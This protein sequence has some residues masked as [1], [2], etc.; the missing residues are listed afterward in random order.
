VALSRRRRQGGN[1]LDAWPGYVDALSTLLLVVIFVLLVFVLGQAFLSVALNGREKALERLSAQVAQLTQMLSLERSHDAALEVSV[2]RAT[3]ALAARER[4]LAGEKKLTASEAASVALLNSQITALR[5]QLAAIAAALDLSQTQLKGRDVQIADLD[6]KLN[7]ALADKVETLKRYRS[8]FFGQLSQVL[9]G[10]KGISVV[11]DRFVFQGEVLFPVGSADLSPA[12][13]VE[14]GKLAETLKTIIPKIP[15]DLGWMLRVD[16]HADRQRPKDGSDA[17]NWQL[18]SERAI[19]V[20]RLL[21]ADGI[22]ASHLAATGFGEYQPLDPA[23]T[24]AAYARN[25][26]IELRLTDR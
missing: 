17:R 5:Q 2:S 12:G 24:Q 11:G 21:V 18:S 4:D 25:R 6:R 9:A 13:R 14:I 7:L 22:P 8:E 23:D 3:A 16:G 20:V 19:S 26:R 15:A 10:Q 1:G